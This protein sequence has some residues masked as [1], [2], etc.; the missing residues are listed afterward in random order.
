LAQRCPS[1]A[2]VYLMHLCGTACY[3]AAADRT[4]PL[5]ADAAAGRHLSTLAFSEKGS[6]SHFWAPVSR[7]AADG[8]GCVRISAHK[9]FVTS[10]GHAAGYV[11]STL[12]PG[13]TQP[14]ASTIY[15]V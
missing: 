8:N 6:R 15:L 3:A 13:A 10:A 12:A 4:A 1:T 2:M 14:L 5:L 7:A 9:S 11:V